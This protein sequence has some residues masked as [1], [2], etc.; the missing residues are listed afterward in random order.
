MALYTFEYIWLD[1]NTNPRSKTKVM[2]LDLKPSNVSKLPVW[3]YDG[4]STGQAVTE[5]SEVEIRPVKMIRDPFRANDTSYLVLC[6]TY[7]ID[8]TPHRDNTR[9]QAVTI[10]N[11]NSEHKEPMFGLEQE[12][13]IS[14]QITGGLI[15]V[16]FPDNQN[17]PRPQG[18][19]YC[20]VGGGNIYGRKYVEEI[21]NKLVLCNLPIT[22]MNAEVAPGQWEFQVCSTGVD[23]ADSLILLRYIV[24]RVLEKDF[25]QMDITAKPIT[26][27]WNG[28][29]CHINY[30]TDL[31][32][33]DGGYKYIE[34][35]LKNLEPAHAL[36]IKHYGDDNSLRLTGLHETSSMDKFS[37]SVGGRN[38]SIRIPYATHE[39]KRGY[40]E[41][42]RPSSSLD[43]YKSTA[44]LHATSVGLN[45]DFWN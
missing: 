26:G 12:F 41:D 44:L 37:Y 5:K 2:N 4:S 19:Y 32:R 13:F 27:D 15:P 43:P 39:T 8:G 22:G 20:G 10:F 3:N 29:G 25:L 1:S 33:N 23:A 40:F 34:S 11:M 16:A 35:A 36:H 7:N 14:R 9:S 45:Q 42:R 31:M 24:N 6:E 17:V 21:L 28:S 30:S 38:T 18:D